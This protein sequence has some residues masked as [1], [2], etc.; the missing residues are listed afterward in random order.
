MPTDLLQAVLD[1][2]QHLSTLIVF[3]LLLA[4]T[5]KFF[6]SMTFSMDLLLIIAAFFGMR[7]LSK[8]QPARRMGRQVGMRP[9]Y[10]KRQCDELF[11]I[12]LA[13]YRAEEA[14]RTAQ[15]T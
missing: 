8:H 6:L 10:T 9:L 15:P 3:V 2:I 7:V 13:G 1:V 12:F 14:A 11:E 5:A 4:I